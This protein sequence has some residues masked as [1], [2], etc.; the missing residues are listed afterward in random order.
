MDYSTRPIT[1]EEIPAFVRA[2][3][4][5]YGNQPSDAD[6]AMWR[7]VLELD[8]SLA[9]FEGERIVATAGAVSFDLTLPGLTTLP[10]A[11]VTWVGVV[12]TH[13]RRGL[14]TALMRRQL[15]DVRARGEA[16]AVL[17]ASES[18]IYGRF[19]YGLATSLL[20]V[21]IDRRHS[22]FA[23]RWDDAGKLS[24]I[25]HERAMTLLPALYE[26]VR[27]RQPGALT[28]GPEWWRFSMH[29]PT[30]PAEGA[31]ARFY[32]IHED[33]AGEVDGAATYRVASHWEHGLSANT[34]IVRNLITSSAEARAALWQYCFGLDLVQTIR[35]IG[36]PVEEPLRWM[37]ADP[38]RLRVSSLVDNLWLRVIDVAV[39]L[40]AR[41]Y[42]V[43]GGVV[44]E[45]S[46]GFCPENSGR[47]ELE[48]SPE[49]ASC[50]RTSRRADVALGVADLGAIYLGGVRL[51][52]LARA[53]R[54]RELR[55][56]ALARADQLFAT[57]TAP[58]CD[59]DF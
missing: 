7:L 16:L 24:L 11:G 30:K 44:L 27:Q 26:R 59:T 45:V 10:V 15:A 41:R 19:G 33:D 56:G 51:D 31:G 6:L 35:A 55:A 3:S 18:V 9:V 14:L 43:A 37:L 50:Q 38:R 47:Y 58:Y 20:N 32:V 39:A 5:A 54:V 52:T 13:R 46:D 2:D 17:T 34:L 4:A 28:R 49:G 25:D 53:G 42:A 29:N 8:R 48:G 21:E 36:L 1:A 22:A 40:A 57:D 12:P 23:R